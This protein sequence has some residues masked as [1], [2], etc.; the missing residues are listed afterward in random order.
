MERITIT[1]TDYH[2]R[3]CTFSLSLTWVDHNGMHYH[4]FN[5]LPHAIPYIFTQFSMVFGLFATR[6]H[7]LRVETNQLKM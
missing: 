7:S 2:T 1:P 3:Y 6:Y 4:N 5:M